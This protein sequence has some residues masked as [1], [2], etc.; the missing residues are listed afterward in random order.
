MPRGRRKEAREG[1]MAVKPTESGRWQADYRDLEGHRHRKTFDRKKDAE[2]YERQTKEEI[3]R[4]VFIAPKKIPT[5]REA[6]EEWLA[7]R[8]DREAAT[9]EFYKMHLEK[10]LFP[11]IGHLK[12]NQIDV[13]TI[14]RKV[15]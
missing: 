6:G 3:V 11:R 15:R 9:Y 10:H 4:G 5:F 13:T 12:L 1:S 2:A 8:A 14:E 7:T